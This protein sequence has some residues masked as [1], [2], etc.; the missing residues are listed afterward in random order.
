MTQIRLRFNLP[1]AERR[2]DDNGSPIITQIDIDNFAAEILSP[3]QFGE[4]DE[5]RTQEIESR[6]EMIATPQLSQIAPQL[7]LTE[8]QKDQVYSIFCSQ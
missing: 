7:G 3:Y 4:Y 2:E 8:T 6:S 1:G 5:I